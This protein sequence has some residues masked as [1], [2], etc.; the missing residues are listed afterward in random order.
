[1]S[2]Y[3]AIVATLTAILVQASSALASELTPDQ[4]AAVTVEQHI[5]GAMPLDLV[6][7]DENATPVRLGDYF[8]GR[9][10][11]LSLN[12]FRCQYIC[13]IEIDGIIS[14]LNG[15]STLTLDR[16]FELLTVSIDSRESP[17]DAQLIRARGLRRYDRPQGANGWHTLTG[18][19]SAVE[20]LTQAVGFSHAYDGQ[21]DAFAHPAGVV[22]LTPTGQ[23]SR[24]LYGPEFSANDLRLALVDAG[25]GRTGSLL[26]RALLICYLYDP[27]TGRYTSLAFGLVRVG[28]VLGAFAMVLALGWLWRTEIG[29]RR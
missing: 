7:R 11:L 1:M 13:P 15:I 9:P 16:D 8:S 14:G 20:Q 12:Y 25:A 28:G 19:S 29:R 22:A 5:G 3:V 6:F 23:I 2:A 21:A 10:V 18:D 26:D 17:A 27:L 24:Y 4:V